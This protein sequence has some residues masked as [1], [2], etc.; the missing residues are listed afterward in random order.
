MAKH[1]SPFDISLITDRI[2]SYLTKKDCSNCILA[3]KTFYNLFKSFLWRNIVN[4]Q[5]KPIEDGYKEALLHN[6]YRIRKLEIVE[7]KSERLLQFLAGPPA[8]CKRL[9][10]FDC[11]LKGDTE[12]Q[13]LYMSFLDIVEQNTSL[14]RCTI[15]RTYGDDAIHVHKRLFKV[16]SNHPSL[17]RLRFMDSQGVHHQVYRALLQHLPVTTDTLVLHWSIAAIGDSGDLLE[18]ADWPDNYP[19]LHT[20]ALGLLLSGHQ[21][22]TVIPFIQRCSALENVRIHHYWRSLSKLITIFGDVQRLPNLSSVSFLMS[23]L[24]EEDWKLLVTGLRG[25]IKSFSADITQFKPSAGAFVK[26]MTTHWSETLQVI[27]IQRQVDVLS[28]EIELILTTCP[29]LRTFSVFTTLIEYGRTRGD[30][31]GIKAWIRDDEE[32]ATADWVCLGLENL[33]LTFLDCRMLYLGCIDE[34]D[35]EIEPRYSQLHQEGWTV[36]GIQRIYQQLGRLTKMVH[37]RIGWHSTDSLYF[38]ANMDMSLKYG[39]DHLKGLKKLRV[40]DIS[41][42]R[43]VK[44]GQEEVEWMVEN[45]PNLRRIRGLITKTTGRFHGRLGEFEQLD[46]DDLITPFD[47]PLIADLIAQYLSKKDYANCIYVSKTFHG[48]FKRYFWYNVNKRLQGDLDSWTELTP[49]YRKGILENGQHI[50]RLSIAEVAPGELLKF[51]ASPSSPCKNLL[52]LIYTSQVYDPSTSHVYLAEL[53]RSNAR[54]QKLKFKLD[55]DENRRGLCGK[56]IDVIGKHSSLMELE[57]SV[58]YQAYYDYQEDF[59][60]HLPKTLRKLKLDFYCVADAY[61]DD[62]EYSDSSDSDDDGEDGDGIKFYETFGAYP[63]MKSFTILTRLSKREAPAILSFIRGCSGLER[64]RVR[65]ISPLV[66]QKFL[67]VLSDAHI[68]SNL[69]EL[70]FGGA[71]FIEPDWRRLLNG[72]QGRI[73]SFSIAQVNFIPSPTSFIQ[74][75]TTQWADS[76]EVL[77]FL[78]YIE[79]SGMDIEW[80]L[81]TCSKLTTFT[82]SHYLNIFDWSGHNNVEGSNALSEHENHGNASTWACL[83][84][85]NLEIMFMD[86]PGSI[87]SDTGSINILGNNVEHQEQPTVDRIELIYKKLGRLTKLQRLRIS[88]LSEDETTQLD[89][90]I[91]SGLNHMS[92]LKGLKVLDVSGINTTNIGQEEVEWIVEN[93]PNLFEIRGLFLKQFRDLF[94]MLDGL[95]DEDEGF[96][97]LESG[98]KQVNELAHFQWLKRQRPYM[99]VS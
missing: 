69:A 97:I 1:I 18:E 73:K 40:L 90:S 36:K 96:G 15:H 55:E 54:L 13:E 68:F 76:L 52:G 30:F 26:A 8:P 45:W 57:A 19:R 83:G 2:G 10:D 70:H 20:L 43:Y 47:I 62:S 51:L 14:Q 4:T 61:E 59:L 66:T 84:L 32:C 94:G 7:F 33:E 98:S 79:L 99:I 82:I 5:L 49:E 17:K 71:T 27:R 42:I 31:N 93:W 80:I 44:I 72:M 35:P 67:A 86:N 39:L 12:S 87:A 9:L 91:K 74:A 92:G 78:D 56:L 11:T 3:N 85:E 75:M 38:N 29:N 81:R 64:F 25:R 28:E 58:T 37:L 16:I 60:L 65:G 50:R 89:M 41:C 24:E 53:V 21:D 6:G 77:R 22:S 46:M 88:W 23:C 63:Q 48:L 95:D 34:M